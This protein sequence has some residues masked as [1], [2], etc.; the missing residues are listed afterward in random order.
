MRRRT[1]QEKKALSLQKDSAKCLWR[2]ASRFPEEHS[3]AKET[4]QLCESADWNADC[5]SSSTEAATQH[6][7]GWPDRVRDSV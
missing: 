5:D 3:P 4:A 6:R 1:P 2:I 7:C